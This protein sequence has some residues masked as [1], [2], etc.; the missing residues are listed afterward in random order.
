MQVNLDCDVMFNDEGE[1]EAY[2]Y[3]GDGDKSTVFTFNFNDIL[4]SHV[5]MFTI[6]ADPPYIQHEDM[7][8]RDSIYNV[9]NVLKAGAEY[10][11]EL[12]N[13]Y[14]D[15]EPVN[16]KAEVVREKDDEC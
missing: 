11:D 6:F 4:K 2:I 7:E 3:I 14:L 12:Q 16:L 10:I 9:S 8:A 1:L 5:E 15:N 13:K